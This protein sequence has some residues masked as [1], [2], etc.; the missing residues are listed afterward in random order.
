M[1]D[2][3]DAIFVS[4][5]KVGK[6]GRGLNVVGPIHGQLRSSNVSQMGI[7]LD[8]VLVHP[9]GRLAGQF[10]VG[11]GLEHPVKWHCLLQEVPDFHTAVARASTTHQQYV[12]VL[13]IQ[14]ANFGHI[15][16]ENNNNKNGN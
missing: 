9:L 7:V 8:G 4:A 5:S 15:M 10:R 16:L 12:T 3:D 14:E 6:K 2:F 1:D 11:G 13:P